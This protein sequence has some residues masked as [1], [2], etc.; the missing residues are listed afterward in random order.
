MWLLMPLEFK[1]SPALETSVFWL[2]VLQLDSEEHLKYAEVSLF[3]TWNLA[4]HKLCCVV[5]IF[6]KEAK[7]SD[8]SFGKYCLRSKL[9]INKFGKEGLHGNSLLLHFPTTGNRRTDEWLWA[10]F[11]VL[12]CVAVCA[13]L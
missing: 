12:M 2:L 9:C 6:L 13:A 5:F 10:C 1:L 4:E 8:A 3:L 11:G 7:L